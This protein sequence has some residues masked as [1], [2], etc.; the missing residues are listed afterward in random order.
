MRR[1]LSRLRLGRKGALEGVSKCYV[2]RMEGPGGVRV[3]LADLL[4][5]D[6][7]CGLERDGW[8]GGGEY[9]FEYMAIFE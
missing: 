7:G 1:S 6:L 5:L 8:A 3:R 2:G 4:P 9:I